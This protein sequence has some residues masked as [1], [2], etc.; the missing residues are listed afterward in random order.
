MGQ[1]ER[2]DHEALFAEPLDDK[3]EDSVGE[4]IDRIVR[5]LELLFGGNPNQI[6]DQN[7]VKYQLQLS[8]GV[9]P[10]RSGYLQAE[11]AALD[12]TVHTR[13]SCQNDDRDSQHI[14]RRLLRSPKDR[15]AEHAY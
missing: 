4:Q 15:R 3:T 9:A 14:H 5:T 1:G 10:I 7:N 8:C 13:Q 2:T 12:Q 6:D 11:T